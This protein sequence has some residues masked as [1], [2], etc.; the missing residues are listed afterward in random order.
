[1]ATLHITRGL[2]AS[3]KT[4]F[5][6]GWVAED[7]EHRARVNRDDLR[8]LMHGGYSKATETQVAAARDA[9]IVSLL[10]KGIDVVCDDTGLRQQVVRG[11]AALAKS[12]RAGFEVHDFTDVPLEVCIERDAKR[13]NPVGEA[14]IRDTWTRYLK[15]RA[16]PLPLPKEPTG[17]D[18]GGAYEPKPGTPRAVLVDVD[19]TVALMGE[20]GP[21][22]W[23][24][25]GEDTPNGPVIAVVRA[26]FAAG[27]RIVV[28][29]GRSEECRTATEAWLSEHLGVP[30][31]GPF[32][33][34]AGDF[35]KDAVVKRELFDAQIREAYDVVCVLDDR[36][37]VV[38]A[39]RAMGLTVL[40][41]AEGNF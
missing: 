31:T 17:H 23:S 9:L 22:D 18:A 3:G 4:T 25:V 6:K 39:W 41:V 14:V 13:E 35:R 12:A 20:R 21:F 28:M 1:M 11:L 24:R 15:G 37:Q 29:S 36:D 38:E 27:Y 30:F 10:R 40:Q 19:G 16:L 33:R 8:T 2:Q 7:P 5:A 34:A 32:M 26:L